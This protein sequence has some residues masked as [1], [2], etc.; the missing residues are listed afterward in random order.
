LAKQFGNRLWPEPARLTER[1]D[2]AFDRTTVMN[3]ARSEVTQKA[4]MSKYAALYGLAV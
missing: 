4:A 1:L 3:K 2:A